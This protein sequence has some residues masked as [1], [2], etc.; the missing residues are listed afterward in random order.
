MASHAINISSFK[1][2]MKK[3]Y[4]FL[5][6]VLSML[7]GTYGQE[8]KITHGPYLQ[9][10][11]E[12]EVTIVWTTNRKA[13]SWVE[14]APSCDESF[15]SQEHP[16]YY[17]T[18]NGNRVAD[19]LHRVRITGLNAAESYR[20]RI[21]SKEILT[22][23]GH[24]VLYGNI[25]STNVYRQ[26]PLRFSTANPARETIN[27]TV[28]NDIHGNFDTL[29]ALTRDVKF[30]TTDLVFF[31]GDMVSS[32]DN[33]AQVLK[34]FMD[35]ATELFAGEVPAFFARGNHE[36]RGAFSIRFPDYFPTFS[37]HPYYSFRQ[38]PVAFIVLDC[39]EDKPDSDIEYSGLADFD[40]Y[41]TEQ[42]EWLKEV[43]KTKEFLD[44]PYRVVILHMPPYGSEWHGS[45][46]LRR[47]F[48]PILNEAG[49]TVML[50]GH[51]HRYSFMEANHGKN[52]FPILINANN[53]SL[54]VM[55]DLGKMT[56]THKNTSGRELHRHEFKPVR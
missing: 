3:F 10:L 1:M 44:A 6:F 37:G 48:V 51:T 4:L 24:R 42:A 49:I 17:E 40:A 30:G 15:Y 22:Y 46:D 32:M 34:G 28:V 8:M 16:K 52:Q 5:V 18:R 47:K 19:T 35:K 9:A 56:I 53:T 23:E 33:E 21:F 38:G 55:A 43:V 20:Y 13:V 2:T 39:G 31:N 12:N 27:F 7:P 25:A 45:R 50:C 11:G 54:E 26:K 41:R 14:V 36:A 29:H